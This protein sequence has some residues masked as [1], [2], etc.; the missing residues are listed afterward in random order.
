M[1]SGGQSTPGGKIGAP[2]PAGAASAHICLTNHGVGGKLLGLKLSGPADFSVPMMCPWCE[3]AED[4]ALH[5][6]MLIGPDGVVRPAL[7]HRLEKALARIFG[8]R[9]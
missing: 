8:G 9:P 1:V 4:F 6:V 2:D 7:E 3:R 5:H